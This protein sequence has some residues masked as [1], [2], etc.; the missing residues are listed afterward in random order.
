MK[1]RYLMLLIVIVILIVPVHL[2]ASAGDSQLP[3]VRSFVEPPTRDYPQQDGGSDDRLFEYRSMWTD[4]YQ[5]VNRSEIQA[6]VKFAVDHNFNCIS[7]NIN[8]HYL[9]V[10]YNSTYFPK[11]V[12]VHWSFD[13]LMELIREAHKYNIHVM[14]WFHTL[15]NYPLLREHPEWRDRSSSGSYSSH[16]IDPANPDARNYLANMTKELF[17]NYP[18]DGIKLDTIRYGSSIYGY[19]DISIQKYYDEGWTNFND[20]RRN[21]VTEVV[22][23]LYNTIMDIRPYVWVGADIW[24]GYWSWYNGVFQDSRTWAQRGI[25]DFVTTMSY[26]TSKSYFQSTLQD[27]LDNFECPVVAGPYVYYPGNTAH[28]SVPSEEAGIDILVNQTETAQRLGA[29]GTCDFAYKSLREWPS[30]AR[31]LRDGPFKEKALCPLKKQSIPVRSTIWDFEDDQDREGWRTTGMGQFYPGGGVWSIS[32]CRAPSLMSPLVH[33]T[34]EGKNVLELSMRADSRSGKLNIYWSSLKPVFS[35]DRKMEIDIIDTEDWHL[36]SIHLDEEE[37]W[38]GVIRYIRIVPTFQAPTN[39]TIDLI[40]LV[41]MPYCVRNWSYLGP[42]VS[43][44]RDSLLNRQFLERENDPRPRLG[45]QMAGNT[46]KPFGMERDQVDLRF[47]LGRLEDAVTY[48]HVY[49]RSEYEGPVELRVGNSDGVKVYF[50]GNEVFEQRAPR[51]VAPDQNLTF[52]IMK[53]GI[54]TVLIKL[55]VYK[56]ENSFYLRFTEPGNTSIEGLEYFEE[57][58]LME[59][60]LFEA[61]P[62]DWISEKDVAIGWTLPNGSTG[63]D[64]FEWRI[65]GSGWNSTLEPSLNLSG[66]NNGRHRLEV[67]AVDEM[68]FIGDISGIFICIDRE[69]PEISEPEP[70]SPITTSPVLSW[71]WFILKKPISG[72]EGYLVT[73]EAW[74]SGRTEVM[75]LIKEM[76]VKEDHFRIDENVQD[77]YLYRIIVEAVSGSGLTHKV[78]SSENI[79]VDLQA[80]SAPSDLIIKHL[81]PGETKYRIDWQPSIDNTKNGVIYYEFWT[82]TNDGDWLITGRPS[83]SG[84]NFERPLGCTM[85]IRIR[86]VDMAG[87]RSQFSKVIPVENIPPEPHIL[88][89]DN[90]VEGA[91]FTISP[92]GIIDQDGVVEEYVWTMNGMIISRQSFLTLTL[93]AGRHEV[94]LQVSDDLGSETRKILYLDVRKAL[95]GTGNSITDTLEDT[96]VKDQYLDPVTLIH[97]N[98][99]T[100]ITDNSSEHARPPLKRTLF[101]GA[102]VVIGTVMAVVLFF[103]LAAI[104]LKEIDQGRERLKM[105][106]ERKKVQKE[107][108]RTAGTG[109]LTMDVRSYQ[110]HTFQRSR[111]L[112]MLQSRGLGPTRAP[113]R[114]NLPRNVIAR[115]MSGEG[116]QGADDIEDYEEWKVEEIED[117][118]H[119]KKLP[120]RAGI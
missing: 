80:P 69:S 91:A 119:Y 32:N 49:V 1:S 118:D 104:F 94:Q 27:N 33:T 56:N 18:L 41:W 120:G 71:D 62:V 90:M 63:L 4:G 23:L 22:D 70:I 64:H 89:P 85:D 102:T 29:L 112:T 103:L 51:R 34:A 44:D 100:L 3:P 67:R 30:Y 35:E 24:H 66:L 98:N 105:S 111:A 106:R 26:T 52:V 42:F 65:D 8:G 77:G 82:R 68:G 92:S 86:A 101:N 45:D 60:P 113:A 55:A 73:V 116:I 58:P 84:Y 6:M 76:E 36:Y 108:I 43:G 50:N 79:L 37:K 61:P 48:V 107:T 59:A 39:I 5:I 11:Y 13:P 15:Y 81:S 110:W 115:P 87:Q 93:S 109:E 97:Y 9:G 47:A 12:E 78:N 75:T 20:F 99:R 88:L 83:T 17:A 95:D 38:T 74:R 46:W 114:E 40:H 2:P 28:G 117:D 7:P 10:F 53:R 16:W 14:P 54:N 72:I 19:T 96:A 21:Q 31:A 25:I 57:L